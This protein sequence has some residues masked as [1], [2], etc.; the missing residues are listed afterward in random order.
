MIRRSR[1]SVRPNVKPACRGLTASRD[2]S[3]DDTQPSLTPAESAPP[4]GSEVMAEKAKTDPP[5]ASSEQ[6]NEETAQSSSHGNQPEAVSH[7][8]DA[9]SKSNESQVATSTSAM[10]GPQRRKRFTALPNLAKPRA[11]SASSRTPKTPPKSPEKS[12]TPNKPETSAPTIAS[13]LHPPVDSEPAR[14]PRAPR[15]RRPSGGTKQPKSQPLPAAPP[16]NIQETEMQES[17]ASEDTVVQT[18]QEGV[19]LSPLKTS[20]PGPVL[21]HKDPPGCPAPLAVEDTAVQ[22]E[23]NSGVAPEQTQP[24]LLSERFKK[25]KSSSKI[26]RSLKTLN[27]PADM[28][29]LARARKLRELLKKEMS[30]NKEEKKKPKMGIKEHKAPKDHTKMTMRELIYYLPASNPMKPFTEEE[31]KSSEIVLP[32][33]PP[34][35]SSNTSDG[36]SVQEEVAGDAGREEVEETERVD[37]TQPEEEEPLLVPRVKVA[38]D[39]SLIIDE[40]SLTVK[41]LRAKG[42]NPAEDRDPIFERGSTTT[43]SSFRKGSY[44]RPWSSGETE[45]FYLA[46][47]MVGTDFSMIGQFFPHRARMEIKN[48]FK[49]EERS[50]SWRIDKAFKEKRRLDLEFFKN[51]MEQIVKVEEVKKKQNK[52]LTK[53]AKAQRTTQRKPRGAKRK[54]MDTSEDSDSDV[55]T[56]EKENEDL[57]NDGGSDGTPK[58]HKRNEVKSLKRRIKRTNGEAPMDEPEDFENVVS[59]GLSPDDRLK[60]SDLSEYITKSP[61]IKPAQLMGRPQRPIPNLSRRC[62]NRHSEGGASAG[63]ESRKSH[64][65]ISLQERQ[66]TLS[67]L[68]RELEDLEEEPDLTA[69]QEQIFN[70]PTRSGRIPKLSQHVIQATAEEEDDEEELSDLPVSSKVRGQ[71]LQAPSKRAKLKQGPSL[72]KGMQRRGKSR[73]VTLRASGTEEDEE[74]EDG[75]VLSQEDF[76]SNPE[77]EN[78]AFVPM[79]LRQLPEVNSEVVETMEELDISVNVPDILGTSHN[80]LCPELSCEQAVMPAGSVPCEHQLDL[81][82]DV[83]EFLDPDHMEVCKEI[84]NEAAQT[85]LTIGNSAQIIQAAETPCIG[86]NDIIEQSSSLVEKEVAI[87]DTVDELRAEALEMM[88]GPS[89]NCESETKYNLDL[90]TCGNSVPEPSREDTVPVQEPI[91]SQTSDSLP[92][93]SQH[94]EQNSACSTSVPPSRMGRF[95][96]PKPNICQ[97]L[98]SRRAQQLQQVPPNHVTDSLESSSGPSSTEQNKNTT[99]LFQEDSGPVDH[100]PQDSSTVYPEVIQLGTS[101]KMREDNCNVVSER[102]AEDDNGSVSSLKRKSDDIVNEE[103]VKKDRKELKEPRSEPQLTNSVSG[104]HG[105]SDEAS[106]PV[107]RFRGP[108][109]KPNLARTFRP[110]CTQTQRSTLSTKAVTNETPPVDS[111]ASTFTDTKIHEEVAVLNTS[112][113]SQNK[114]QQEK[115]AQD[116]ESVEEIKDVPLQVV[117]ESEPKQNAVDMSEENTISTPQGVLENTLVKHSGCVSVDTSADPTPDEPLFTLSLT[118]IPPSFDEEVGLGTEPLPPTAVPELHSDTRS[119]NEMEKQ[120]MEASHRLITDALVPVSEEEEQEIERRGGG[121]GNT[122][123]KGELVRKIT[124]S[125]S[126]GSVKA[127]SQADH[128]VEVLESPLAER[129][130]EEKEHVEKTRKHPERSRRAKLQVK[131]NPV[132]RRNARGTHAKEDTPELS[133]EKTTSLPISTQETISVPDETVQAA[134]STTSAIPSDRETARGLSLPSYNPALPTLTLPESSSDLIGSP[135]LVSQENTSKESAQEGSSQLIT[136][137][138]DLPSKGT[139]ELAE[140]EASGLG[141]D[142]QSVNQITPVATTGTLTR[143]GRRPKGFLSFISSKNTQGPPAA[144]REA[145][146]GPQKPAVNIAHPGRKLVAT[147][148]V[149]TAANP[150]VQ[151]PSPTPTSSTTSAKENFQEEPTSVS[152]YFFSDIFTEVDELE[153][154]D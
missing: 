126:H 24:D 149:T 83:I 55:E 104:S 130:D 99:E 27:D 150:G 120:S 34:L 77:E 7:T 61:A 140:T 50:N 153:D 103:S 127:K 106:K 113:V 43:Y 32:N 29:R 20:Q 26:L 88:S 42:P 28:I 128:H 86:E 105:I 96:K 68:L 59:D 72:K 67:T 12:V 152:K 91:K 114:V 125:R 41:V 115:D 64:K 47:S 84:N 133:L 71:G 124:L 2:V 112:D 44:T 49:K 39:G 122:V 81:L 37:E 11:S 63:E 78:Q 154:M 58:K 17:G 80:A 147:S 60:E 110:I 146:P 142:S 143:P 70:K 79:S 134:I 85:L 107:R 151:Q 87:T 123:W 56:G 46:I 141:T 53:L 76:P 139:V 45:M 54:E 89:I 40:E 94:E 57:S 75:V 38:E 5:I 74:E 19:S 135:Q 118:E 117:S 30:R 9:A 137:Q 116:A 15:R 3:L 21:V 101:S 109:P 132:S 8:D 131:P 100:S 93:P 144:L 98:R 13:A 108:K 4:E 10:S 1:I 62:G 52:A 111:P 148:P 31:Q 121:D 35:I 51:M 25:R 33:S 95:S 119:T 16:Q 102:V 18:V 6:T 90:S 48:K 73:L 97:G 36:P 66:K 65:V 129:T 138:V 82:I 23:S 14:S 136:G 69:V 22:E 92:G 145:K